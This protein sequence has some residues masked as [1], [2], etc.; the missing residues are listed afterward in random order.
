MN[1]ESHS[2]KVRICFSKQPPV[3]LQESVG[4]KPLEAATDLAME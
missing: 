3:R 1:D 2:Y 4:E